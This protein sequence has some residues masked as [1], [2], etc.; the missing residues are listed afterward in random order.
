MA[1]GW[2]ERL[3]EYVFVGT[4]RLVG[5][6]LKKSKVTVVKQNKRAVAKRD[7][8][9]AKPMSAGRAP[10][11]I[12]RVFT[13]AEFERISYGFIPRQMEDKWFIYFEE[14][15]LYVHRSWTGDCIFQVKF[16]QSY[17]R[18][19]I[20]QA[21]MSTGDVLSVVR[22]YDDDIAMLLWLIDNLLLEKETPFPRPTN[23][24]WLDNSH[25]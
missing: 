14:N 20:G 22:N 17:D 2:L 4:V 9:E 16:V 19:L 3:A 12:D 13:P 8:W 1:R 24:P 21:W 7:S 6:I 5:Y 11:K 23:P 15:W 18:Y 25:S 10:L